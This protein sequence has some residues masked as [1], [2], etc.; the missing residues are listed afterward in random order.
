MLC[1]RV[2]VAL[3]KAAASN[4]DIDTPCIS[5]VLLSTEQTRGSQCSASPSSP[6]PHQASTSPED[7]C[8]KLLGH[9][10]VA[11][12]RYSILAA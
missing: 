6:K 4:M 7:A 3:R 9:I 11:V 12:N 5:L 10:T 2:T 8:T 1:F